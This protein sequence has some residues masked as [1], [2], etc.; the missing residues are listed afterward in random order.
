MT[1]N[2][3]TIDRLLR[4][5]LVEVFYMLGFFWFAGVWQT[6]FYV[7]A[8][9]MLF[10]A[11]TGFCGVYK[12]FGINTD[13]KKPVSSVTKVVFVFLFI[14]IGL[15]GSYASDFFS[16]KFFLDDYNRMNNYYK[17]TLFNTGQDKRLES[18]SNY[19]GLISE[20]SIFSAKYF[21][22]HPYVISGDAQFNSDLVNVQ[23]I[24]LGLKENVYNGDLKLTHKDFE[25]I[26][27]I[28]QDILKRNGFSMLQV[29]LVD[30]HDAMEKIIA[31]ADAKDA[32]GIITVYSEVDTK[33]KAVEGVANDSEIQTIR[34][35]LDEVLSLAKDGRVDELSAKA[36]E[37]K[38]SFVKVYLVRG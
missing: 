1:K 30:F 2:E 19:D 6:V 14:F 16:R 12:L 22:Y 15:A 8:I 26:R 3:G 5:I 4:L 17:Q 32:A 21:T 36:A 20:F 37:L 27:P 38:S 10:T 34:Q 29:Y 24:I 13:D 23:N 28:F 18:I 7:L 35:K 9:V 31:A 33:L 11:L 25:V